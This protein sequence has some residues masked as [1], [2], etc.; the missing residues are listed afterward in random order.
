[1]LYVHNPSTSFFV[2]AFAQLAVILL[3]AVAVINW[4]WLWVLSPL[5]ITAAIGVYGS[6]VLMV[7]TFI[8]VYLE[9]R[10][11]RHGQ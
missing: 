10:R 5:W 2:F 9:N 4:P 6:L 8:T 3:K 7:L 11:R 1:M